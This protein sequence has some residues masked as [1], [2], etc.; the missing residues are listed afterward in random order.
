MA[1]HADICRKCYQ[2]VNNCQCEDEPFTELQ[3]LMKEKQELELKI[4][5]ITRRIRE[6]YLEKKLPI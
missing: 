4:N 6:I 1:H 3:Q 2:N 5:A